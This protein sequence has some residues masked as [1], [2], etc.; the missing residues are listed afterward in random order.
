VVKFSIT[1][2]TSE[3]FFYI[4]YIKRMRFRNFCFT[5]FKID[6]EFEHIFN[7]NDKITYLIAGLEICPKTNRPHIQGYCE[8]KTQLC[9][10]TIKKMFDDTK[11][12]IELRKGTAEQASNYCKKD[13]NYK[14]YGNISKQGQ[15]SDLKQIQQDID[16][17]ASETQIWRDYFPQSVR[18]HKAFNR[19]R[20]LIN[21]DKIYR[22]PL[23]FKLDPITDFYKTPLII[24]DAGI[25]KT[26]Y[27]LSHFN[28][29][30]LVT[31]IDKLLDFDPAKYDGIIFDDIDWTKLS[32]ETI[33]FL[34]DNEQP[35]QINCRYYIANIPAFTKKMICSNPEY[36]PDMDNA[37]NRR[38]I[39]YYYK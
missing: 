14:Q 30:L 1:F 10:N 6:I 32:R 35:R 39:V 21:N 13:N 24:G 34:V 16:K 23:V 20:S 12:H 38:T 4:A 29:P 15:R 22:V 31:H 27:A 19:Y 25:G 8:L 2:T 5:C 7:Q 9:L 11:I 26:Q 37:I 33:L 3:R 17:G 28:N 36:I 18:Y